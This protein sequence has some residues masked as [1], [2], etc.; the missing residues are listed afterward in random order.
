MAFS[1]VKEVEIKRVGMACAAENCAHKGRLFAV[2]R[3]ICPC[4]ATLA[5][6]EK[7][8]GTEKRFIVADKAVASTCAAPVTKGVRVTRQNALTGQMETKIE[9]LEIRCG[10][11][12]VDVDAANGYAVCKEHA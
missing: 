3:K 10:L 1:G 6:A 5:R 12:A 2:T 9:S 7:P 11:R 8:G 4:G